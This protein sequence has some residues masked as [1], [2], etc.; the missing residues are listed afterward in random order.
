MKHGIYGNRKDRR[1]M[2]A[3]LAKR[4][5]KSLR[6]RS[7]EEDGGMSIVA[8]FIFLLMLTM[9]GISVDVMR[10]EMERTQLQATLD[11]A[12]L[13]GA[14]APAGATKEDI[15][16]II[17]DFFAKSGKSDY[18]NT[19]E[20]G[21]IV[22]TLNSRSVTASA[23]MTINTYIMKLMGVNTLSA[24]GGATAEVRTPK[25]EVALVL[26]VSGSM[27]GTKLSSLKTAAKEFVTTIL[28]SADPGDTVISVIPFSWS[29]SPGPTIL[30]QLTVNISHGYSSCL[31]F[32]E[33]DYNETFINPDRAYDQMIYTAVY[34]EFDDHRSGWRSCFGDEYAEVLP[35]SMSE[36][37]LHGKIDEMVASGNTSGHIGVKWGAAFLDPAFRPVSAAFDA[38]AEADKMLTNVPANYFEPESLKIIVMM[39]DGAN[40]SSYHFDRNGAFRGADGPLYEVTYTAMEFQYAYHIYRHW[41]RY[42]ESRCSRRNWECVYEASDEVQSAYFLR[43]GNQYYAIETEEWISASEFNDLENT[44][45]GYIGTERK[46]WEESWGRFSPQWYGEITGDWSAW[47]DYVGSEVDTGSEKNTMMDNICTATK[48]NGVVIYT[49]GFSVPQNGT[50]ERELRDCASDTLNYYRASPTTISDAFGSIAANVQNLRLTQ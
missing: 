6:T 4:F 28:N 12:V 8:L 18:L 11:S 50:A 9:G 14:G 3:M 30:D 35:F 16:E 41:I 31:R 43:Y 5:V 27:A 49:I 17:E 24:G 48:T 2:Q 10:H 33:D 36:S 47:N 46:T 20:D 37:A 23:D 34:G 45:D 29:V 32:S 19:I 21:D 44:V 42:N 22:A 26:D 15:E 7:G 13:A 1:L 38:E 25:L 40:T 39:G